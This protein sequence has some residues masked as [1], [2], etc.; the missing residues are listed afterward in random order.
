MAK[1]RGVWKYR[2]DRIFTHQMAV[3]FVAPPPADGLTLMDGEFVCGHLS[4]DGVLTINAG[5]AWDGC[6]PKWRIGDVLIGTPDAAP[7][8]DTGLSKT[9]YASL[10]HDI[11]CQFE[12][13]LTPHLPRYHIDTEFYYR[14]ITDKFGQA[15][16]Y[17]GAVRVFAWARVLYPVLIGWWK[18]RG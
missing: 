17:Y 3:A 6:S 7:D 13:V 8:E 10:V 11:L 1:R 4:P 12:A 15:K 9:Y 18:R 2:L 14:L 16:L 5:Y